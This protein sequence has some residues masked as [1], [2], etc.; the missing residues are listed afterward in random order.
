M[1]STLARVLWFTVIGWWLGPLWFLLSV[2]TMGTIVLFPVGAY[3][4]TKTWQVMTLSAS[5][6][7]EFKWY[8]AEREPPRDYVY[9]CAAC[10]SVI[11]ARASAGLIEDPTKRRSL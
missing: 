4:A 10:A 2:A 5:P 7:V 8:E 9:C 6:T 11:E 3:A 1:A